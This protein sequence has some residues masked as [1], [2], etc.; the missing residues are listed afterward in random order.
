MIQIIDAGHCIAMGLRPQ[1]AGAID[2]SGRPTPM[3]APEPILEIPCDIVVVAIGQNIQWDFKILFAVA[4]FP[5]LCIAAAP[6]RAVDKVRLRYRQA[7]R[8]WKCMLLIISKPTMPD[9]VSPW[10]YGLKLP[11]PSTANYCSRTGDTVAASK[12]S[13][14]SAHG[15]VIVSGDGAAIDWNPFFSEVFPLN[16]NTKEREACDRKQDF[17]MIEYSLSQTEAKQE[18]LRCLRC[19]KHGLGAH[20]GYFYDTQPAGADF[21]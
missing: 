21:I 18:A 15:T 3:D 11:A 14:H 9:I 8:Y 16:I 19:D 10:V 5:L 13:F 7:V 4:C 1:I 20:T 6:W 12:Q 2:R 17:E